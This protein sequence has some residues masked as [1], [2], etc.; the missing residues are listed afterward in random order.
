GLGARDT[1]RLEAGL[2]LYGNDMDENTNPF[3]AKLDAFVNLEKKN[4]VGKEKLSKLKDIPLPRVR[5]GIAMEDRGIPRSHYPIFHGDREIGLITSGG[6]SITHGKMGIGM[7]YVHPD[8]SA[9]GTQVQVIIKEKP[10]LA[11]V[12]DLMKLLRELKAGG[13]QS[14]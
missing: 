5:V 6:I 3:E 4:F 10:R 12:V 1:L 9:L 2:P 13:Y 11:K 7:G 14:R 8:F